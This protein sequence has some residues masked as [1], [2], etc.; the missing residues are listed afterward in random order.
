MEQYD[1]DL[2][3][4][5]TSGLLSDRDKGYISGWLRSGEGNTKIAQRLSEQFAGTVDTMQL[6]TGETADFRA[7]T[8]GVERCV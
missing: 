7:S 1:Q 6:V 2:R 4:V 5:L 3:E 8:T